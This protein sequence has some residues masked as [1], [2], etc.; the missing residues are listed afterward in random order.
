MPNPDDA[1]LISDVSIGNTVAM[2]FESAK[3]TVVVC[4]EFIGMMGLGMIG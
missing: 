3:T 4:L 1:Y 2:N